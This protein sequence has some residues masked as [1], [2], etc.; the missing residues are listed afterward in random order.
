MPRSRTS[1]GRRT[2][3]IAAAISGLAI[4][5]AG[6]SIAALPAAADPAD[7]GGAPPA[8]SGTS[9]AAA[10]GGTH[11]V[12]LITGD[13]VH[14][15]DLAGGTHAVDIEPAD[16]D[17]AVQTAEV[18][19]DLIVLPQSAMP[20]LA[21]GLL[22][23]DLFNVTRLIEFGY[24]D[25]SVAATPIIVEFADGPALRSAPV[26][27]VEIGTSLESIGGAAATAD[28]ASA[29]STWNALTEASGPRTFSSE[30]S[31]GGGIEAIHLDGKVQATLDSSVG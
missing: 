22:D 25:A 29:A 17:S 20:Y 11:T 6:V 18:D 4:G 28:H 2:R 3:S 23:Q 24:D 5:V 31:L 14:V 10:A 16:P 13:R 15:T 27:G 9:P 19:G 1:R 12:T 21:A 30:V 26:P 7:G 8:A